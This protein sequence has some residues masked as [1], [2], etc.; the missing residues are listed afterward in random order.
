MAKDV[1]TRSNG[2]KTKQLI[3]NAAETLFGE[4]GYD[5]VSLRDITEEAGVTLALASYHFGTKQN[6]FESVVGRRAEFLCK[7]REN[8]L[9]DLGPDASLR[10]VLDAFMAPL[11]EQVRSGDPGWKSYTQVLSRLAEGDRWLDLLG[12]HFNATA[13][14]FQ[15]RLR[16]IRPECDPNDLIRGLTMVIQLMLVTVS[17][18][19]RIDQL[20]EN[21]ARADDF[22]TAYEI[23]LDF[24]EAGISSVRP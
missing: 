2:N 24:T 14:V 1:Q 4:R 13:Y 23:L 20:T 16:D 19:R 11:F 3:L 5:L 9:H 10:E 21:Q 12:R 8:R 22:E 6:L 17:S 15:N 18:H 7:T